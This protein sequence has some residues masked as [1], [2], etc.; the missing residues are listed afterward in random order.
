MLPK[1]EDGRG[2]SGT[3]EQ[4]PMNYSYACSFFEK[5]HYLRLANYN[6]YSVQLT[7]PEKN[8]IHVWKETLSSKPNLRDTFKGMHLA[9]LH[10]AAQQTLSERLLCIQ[11]EI[12][13]FILCELKGRSQELTCFTLPV[14]DGET[15]WLC[16]Q[17]HGTLSFPTGNVSQ[18]NTL[19]SFISN[20]NENLLTVPAQK[21]WV[22]FLGITGAS[23]Q[24][25]L[26]EQQMLRKQYDRQESNITAPVT[27][28]YSERKVL[29]VFSRKAF[30]PFTTVHHIGLL[31]G[32]LYTSY[33]RQLDKRGALGKEE[34]LI[35]LHHQ[36][37]SYITENY[38]DEQ[39]NLEKVAAA[40]HS[41]V[42]NLQRAFE[43]RSNSF[44]SSINLIRLYKSRE[45]LRDRPELTVE[46]IAGML[47]FSDAK[48]FSTQYKKCFHRTPREERKALIR[49]K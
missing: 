26:A 44:K 11:F 27:I 12:H 37:I 25:L 49:P 16:L 5:K 41:S 42:R 29:E 21:Q 43:G 15:L 14:Q 6:S 46:H 13:D 45:L 3:K 48:H 31:L 39:L 40:C 28:S 10:Q 33:A 23:R 36:A 35:V 20:S 9:V 34:G 24:Q 1:Q 22:L 19:F 4:E 2:L 30:G 8:L 7:M 32:K 18:P 17:F 38:M 47:F